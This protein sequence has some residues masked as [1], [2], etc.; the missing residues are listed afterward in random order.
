[1]SP[2]SG[3]AAD[4]VGTWRCR[5]SHRWRCDRRSHHRLPTTGLYG[6]PRLRTAGVRT[7]VL[8]G[9]PACLR[10][11]RPRCRLYRPTGTG[12]PWLCC[13]SA[14]RARRG[15]SRLLRARQNDR[16]SRRIKSQRSSDKHAWDIAQRPEILPKSGVRTSIARTES[17]ANLQT[18]YERLWQS[19][20][21]NDK[22]NQRNNQYDVDDRRFQQF[23]FRV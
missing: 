6:V 23:L 13:A 10:R 12:L 3:G 7:R 11:C 5:R 14:A 22:C 4:G 18:C 15:L 21:S 2:L 1:M 9:I 16:V 19:P 17:F 8:L 20:S